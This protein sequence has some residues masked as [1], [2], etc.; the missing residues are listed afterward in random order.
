MSSVQRPDTEE[1]LRLAS[2][3][4]QPAIGELLARHRNRLRRMVT[5]RM[6][7]RLQARIDPSDVVQEALLEASQKLP[8]Y[9]CDRPLPY[10]PWLRQL[11]WQRLHD[12]HLRHLRAKKR[13]VTREEDEAIVLSDESVVQLARVAAGGTS[14]SG[15]VLRKE[16]HGRVREALGRM[17]AEDQEV[18]VLRYLEQLAAHEIAAILGI[19]AEAVG[20]RHLRA[21]KRLRGLLREF[22]GGT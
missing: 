10:Y 15:K 22:L 5:V 17:K 1:L 3:G 19:S 4:D 18:L 2:R 20:M 16:A 6:D 13:T 21:L 8:Q 14:P 11:A 12:H 7:H 9:L